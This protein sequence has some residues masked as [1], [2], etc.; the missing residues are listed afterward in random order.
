MGGGQ[1]KGTLRATGSA[2]KHPGGN[3]AAKLG[4]LQADPPRPRPQKARC[5]GSRQRLQLLPYQQGPRLGL[6][7]PQEAFWGRQNKPRRVSRAHVLRRNARLMLADKSCKQAR[8]SSHSVS[9]LLPTLRSQRKHFDGEQRA[10]GGL[11]SR[12]STSGPPELPRVTRAEHG[13]SPS[14]CRACSSLEQHFLWA[15]IL[16]ACSQLESFLRNLESLKSLFHVFR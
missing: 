14:F 1:D 2:P 8:F 6:F 11:S 16:H 13:I 15:R 9:Q 5:R 10:G 4:A 7:F 12:A 3:G